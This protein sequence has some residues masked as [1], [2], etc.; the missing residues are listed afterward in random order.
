VLCQEKIIQTHYLP[1]RLWSQKGEKQNSIKPTQEH[2][3]MEDA[4]KIH[5][6]STLEKYHGHRGDT[7]KALHINKSTLWRKMKKYKLIHN[8]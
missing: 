7:A 3:P 4:E 6:I 1:E 8:E 2:D 5:I